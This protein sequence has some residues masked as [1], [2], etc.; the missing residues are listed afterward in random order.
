[1]SNYAADE[2]RL[3]TLA[4]GSDSAW[5]VLYD[6]LRSPFRLFFLKHTNWPPE[7]VSALYQDAM[8]VLHRKVTTG[9]LAAPLRSSL[10]TYLFGVGKMIYR[11]QGGAKTQWEEEVPEVAIPP[12]VEDRIAQ[13]EQAAWIRNLLNRMDE[14]CRNILRKVY[15]HSYSMEAIAEDL[16]LS[17]AGAARKRKYDCLQRMRKLISIEEN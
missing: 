3:Q 7:Q 5:R 17:G 13:R 10:R 6:D 8:V 4:T 15:L 11:K 14:K 12:G 1:M 9:S 2:S 16:G